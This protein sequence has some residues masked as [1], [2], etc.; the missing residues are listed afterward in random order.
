MIYLVRPNLHLNLYPTGALVYPLRVS[1]EHI[2]V[3]D[4][5]Q[6]NWDEIT[7]GSECLGIQHGVYSTNKI[8]ELLRGKVDAVW[9]KNMFD[10]ANVYSLKT[11]DTM[12]VYSSVHLN[13]V[14]S[15]EPVFQPSVISANLEYS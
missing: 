8:V 6:C 14:I 7:Y 10:W 4:G 5:N 11:S 13:Y 1:A 15:G 3:I 9:I 2:E 12:Y